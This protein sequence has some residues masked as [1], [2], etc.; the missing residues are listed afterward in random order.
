[1][2]LATQPNTIASVFETLLNQ[3]PGAAN[4]LTPLRKQAF[5]RFQQLGWPTSK[6]E[7]WRFTNP[8]IL[9]Q[10]P[11]QR[12]TKL[13]QTMDTDAITPYLIG[14]TASR[15]V[16]VDGHFHSGLSSLEKLPEGCRCERLRDALST[17]QVAILPSLKAFQNHAAQF[18]SL[19]TAFLEDGVVLHLGAEVA[20]DAPVQI[21][22]IQTHTAQPTMVHPR[23]LVFASQHSQASL[24]ETYVGM[25]DA[26]YWV[27]N[28]TQIHL[29]HGAQ[30]SHYMAQFDSQTSYHVANL[31]AELGQDSRLTC[32]HL[33]TGAA[34]MRNNITIQLQGQGAECC[35]NGLSLGHKSQVL[36]NHVEVNH[37][38]PNGR[39]Q[40]YFK[41][42]LDDKAHGVFGG[43]VVVYQDAQKTDAQQTNRNL[44]LSDDARID[45][46]PQ[47]EIYADDVKCAH[48]ATTGQLDTDALF[49]LA[50]RGLDP[51]AAREVLLYAFAHEILDRLDIAP[52]LDQVERVLLS[53]F[54]QSHLFGG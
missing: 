33:L 1:M 2:N 28:V 36:D 12:S 48:G 34:L 9:A 40:Q 7:A 29:A 23:V 6:D 16:F 15:L 24:V 52:V 35:V 41:T 44:L 37:L 3:S 4:P 46:K 32:H 27:N 26:E 47:L 51:K 50:S 10:T 42:I 17:N 20:L 31:K 21:L 45:T 14:E 49:Y 38:V 39:S 19:N 43:R 8:K 22:H 53:R 5:S 25:E 13:N 54:S 18:G 30:F 11:F